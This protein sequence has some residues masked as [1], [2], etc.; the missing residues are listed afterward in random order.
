MDTHIPSFDAEKHEA[1]RQLFASEM[2]ER[3]E[4]DLTILA[5]VQAQVPVKA[6]QQIQE[7]LSTSGH[8]YSYQI[9]KRL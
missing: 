9:V 7:T 3:R 6:F 1:D 2:H 4:R 5:Q 8:T